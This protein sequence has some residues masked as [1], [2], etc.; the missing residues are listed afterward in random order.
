MYHYT[1][2]GQE[3]ALAKKAFQNTAVK[4]CSEIS[5]WKNFSLMQEAMG[6]SS[7]LSQSCF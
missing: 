1:A 7:F 3:E 6:T 2:S 5:S 4:S